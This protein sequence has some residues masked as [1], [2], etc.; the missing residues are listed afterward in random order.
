NR[1]YWNRGFMTEA[2]EMIL[3]FIF[4]NSEINRIEAFVE[5]PNV[6][7]QKLLQKLGFTKEGTL[8]QYEKCRGNLIDIII[9]GYLRKDGKF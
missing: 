2:L 8:R 5:I 3:K 4:I 7:S 6:A 9:Y 1:N